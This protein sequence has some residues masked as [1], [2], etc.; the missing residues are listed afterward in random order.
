M[1]NTYFLGILPQY[2]A[3]ETQKYAIR[4]NNGR[5]RGKKTV[6]VKGLNLD[7]T[8]LTKMRELWPFM[9]M[10]ESVPQTKT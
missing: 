1:R 10:Q 7:D 5:H 8:L 4:V 6:F 2:D 9:D 3:Y